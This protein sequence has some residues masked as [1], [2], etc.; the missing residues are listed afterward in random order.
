MCS[1]EMSAGLAAAV[2]IP[3]VDVVGV[4]LAQALFEMLH[5][6]G[7]VGRVGLGGEDDLLALGSE[8]R[9]DHALVVAVLVA[10]RGV[11]VV[12]AE[13][14]GARDHA[15]VGGDHAAEADRGDA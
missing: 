8:R 11:E 3:D 15:G 6:A 4:E 1:S 13:V 2:Q 7:F 14:G 9:A 10:A 12:D 5:H